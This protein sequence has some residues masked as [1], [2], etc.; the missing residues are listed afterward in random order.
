[1]L[2]LA[3]LAGTV[4]LV[5]RS[6]ARSAQARAEAQALKSDAQRLG[7]LARGEPNLDR[8]F[9]LAVAGMQL[10]IS[11]TRVTCLPCFRRRLRSLGS[12]AY[13]EAKSRRSP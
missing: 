6:R 7:T 2:A 5:Q 12:P 13:R 9:L 3:V 11:R 4:A 8:A 10:L 1:M